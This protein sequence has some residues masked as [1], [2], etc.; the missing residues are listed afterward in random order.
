LNQIFISTLVLTSIILLLAVIVLLVRRWLGFSGIATVSIENAGVL[1]VAAGRLLLWCLADE[2]IHLP[3]AC[4]G[5]GACGQC[6]V[7]I[8]KGYPKLSQ[9]GAEHINPADA[10]AGYRLAC[11]VRVWEDM[12]VSLGQENPDVGHWECEVVS[13]ESLS[14]YLKKLIL[15]LPAQD[16]IHFRAGDYVQVTVPPYQLAF[17]NL[18]ISSPYAEEWKR[19]GLLSLKINVLKPTMRAYSL[20]NPPSLDR[21]IHL[22][23]RI[24]TPPA[25]SPV[26][27]PP[28]KAS[29]Y[30]FNLK[31]GDRLTVSGPFGEFHASEN[32]IEM[33][34][35]AGGAGIAPI[36]SIILDRFAQQPSRRMSLWLGARDLH[37][38]VFYEE[39]QRLADQHQN[40]R[41]E[42]VLSNPRDD[43][44]WS[45]ATGFVHSVVH[46]NYLK[47]HPAPNLAEYY[48]CG[49]PLMTA[50]VLQML[51]ELGV[52]PENI[53]MDDF[54]S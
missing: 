53:F 8:L 13:N 29:S 7:R 1:K 50:A 32:E 22:V 33:V 34:F 54:D 10:V 17:E 26:D 42:A 46:K 27:T 20:A 3:A 39:F 5:K 43:D 16:S 28:G 38:L 14:V 37:D 23:V 51:D 11:M 48:M 4:G 2:G 35:I 52:A 40:F 47:D 44:N 15:R 25:T 18:D 6:R 49:P 24:A 12:L 21:E 45:G 19:L 30:L 41:F 36:H 31:P 9:M